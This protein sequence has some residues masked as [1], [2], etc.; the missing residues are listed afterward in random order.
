MV[1]SFWNDLLAEYRLF[2]TFDPAFFFCVPHFTKHKKMS[3][4][5]TEPSVFA[6]VREI[7]KTFGFRTLLERWVG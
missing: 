5:T 4:A 3:K 1:E 7:I 6:M 2:R